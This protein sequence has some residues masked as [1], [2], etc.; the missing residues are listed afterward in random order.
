MPLYLLGGASAFLTTS[1]LT[2]RNVITKPNLAAN[3]VVI[4]IIVTIIILV[5]IISVRGT[6]V[7][8]S[9]AEGI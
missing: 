3:D 4:I 8:F 5:N 7:S 2:D 9:L 1:F 6:K